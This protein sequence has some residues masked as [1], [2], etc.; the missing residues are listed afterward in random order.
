M[1][2]EKECL[3]QTEEEFWLREELKVEKALLLVLQELR[4][5]SYLTIYRLC[6]KKLIFKH[7]LLLNFPKF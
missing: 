1:V 6:L 4:D 2:S 5:N 3:R 7:F